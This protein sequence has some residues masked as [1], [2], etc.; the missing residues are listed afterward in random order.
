MCEFKDCGQHNEE[1]CGKYKFG[2]FQRPS[3][4]ITPSLKAQ[5]AP[6]DEVPCSDGLCS[7]TI[8]A[9]AKELDEEADRLEKLWLEFIKSGKSGPTTDYSSIFKKAA[10]MIR[11]LA[12]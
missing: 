2:E 6:V 12:P 5:K 3:C 8:E 1:S 10:E 7:A 11:E 9:C 4:Y